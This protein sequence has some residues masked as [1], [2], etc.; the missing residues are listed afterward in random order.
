[1]VTGRG[2]KPQKCI[3][4]LTADGNR[5]ARPV[6]SRSAVPVQLI[7]AMEGLWSVVSSCLQSL[8]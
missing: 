2:R 1:M 4:Q 7:T 8:F 3:P 5:P 6:K